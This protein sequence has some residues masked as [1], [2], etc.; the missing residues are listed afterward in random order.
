MILGGV[1]WS[2][3][4]KESIRFRTDL[5]PYLRFSSTPFSTV[6]SHLQSMQLAYN[7]DHWLKRGHT[8]TITT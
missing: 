1:G 6:R 5:D 8:A 4:R 3:P 2:Y 7:S